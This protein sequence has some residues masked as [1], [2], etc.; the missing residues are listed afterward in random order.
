MLGIGITSL[1]TSGTPAHFVS[2]SPLTYERPISIELPRSRF[3]SLYQAF[4]FPSKINS[5]IQGIQ[6]DKTTPVA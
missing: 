6:L 1:D 3:R 4:F 5:I 2:L